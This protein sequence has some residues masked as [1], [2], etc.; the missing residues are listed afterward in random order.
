MHHALYE[1]LRLKTF[2]LQFYCFLTR[3]Y[4]NDNEIKRIDDLINLNIARLNLMRDDL[5]WDGR[6]DLVLN[7]TLESK[8]IIKNPQFCGQ[9]ILLVDLK[10]LL[11][12]ESMFRNGYMLHDV[13][14]GYPKENLYS[15]QIDCID[16]LFSAS[17]FYNEAYDY[18]HNRKDIKYY[19]DKD[20]G[21]IHAFEMRRI[22][23][24]E[25][26]MFR[27]F[28]EA[29]IN[30][31]F[32]IESFINSV[33]IDAFLNGI[34][35]TEDEENKLK[36]IESIKKGWINYSKLKQRITNISGIINGIPI[37]TTKEPIKS[38]LDISVELRNQYVHS[39]TNKPKN[40]YTLEEW[41]IKCDEMINNKCFG[42]LNEFWKG[43]YPTKPFPKVIF[44]EF[45]GNCFKGHQGKFVITE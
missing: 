4:F 11:N 9:G 34:A 44:N 19:D 15:F 35:K 43:C 32:F 7:Q 30:I 36:G 23:S 8:D 12:I 29:Y 18:Y 45:N 6:Y 37:D 1:E 16:Y 20:F 24:K 2:L 27:N 26:I 38:Y 5:K 21:E 42:V 17:H 33:G 25:E 3:G 28:R 31:I 39:S 41:K 40:R 10:S 13:F 14:R 22:Q